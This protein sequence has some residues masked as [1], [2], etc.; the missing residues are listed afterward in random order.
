MAAL[1]SILDP[2]EASLNSDKNI[3]NKQDISQT[4]KSKFGKILDSVNNNYDFSSKSSEKISAGNSQENSQ[5]PVKKVSENRSLKQTEEQTQNALKDKSAANNEI[6]KK[7]SIEISKYAMP[8]NINVNNQNKLTNIIT[9]PEIMQNKKEIKQDKKDQKQIQK[10]NI[11]KN[12]NSDEQDKIQA[13]T[14]QIAMN[15]DLSAIHRQYKQTV[16]NNQNNIDN[17]KT[18]QAVQHKNTAGKILDNSEQTKILRQNLKYN[19]LQQTGQNILQEKQD[20]QFR[21]QLK[22]DSISQNKIQHIDEPLKNLTTK[23]NQQES[24]NISVEKN[25][26]AQS[27]PSTVPELSQNSSK[28]NVKIEQSQLEGMPN[29][30]QNETL[31]VSGK[32]KN[33]LEKTGIKFDKIE[34]ISV[35]TKLEIQKNSPESSLN[36]RNSQQHSENSSENALI[37]QISST[38]NNI[39][40]INANDNI[41]FD[42]IDKIIESKDL[43]QINP[44]LE[45]VNNKISNFNNNN[46]EITISLQPENL[47]KVDINLVTSNGTLTAQITTENLKVKDAL[48]KDLDV[49]KQNLTDQGIN[50]DKLEI[51]VQK[52]ET[53]NNNN[54]NLQQDSN[55]QKFEQQLNQ[56]ASSQNNQSDKQAFYGENINN[57]YIDINNNESE[58]DT[59][60]EPLQIND[61]SQANLGRVD[62]S[63]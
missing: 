23:Q 5:F 49:L 54:N 43:K 13:A 21:R 7:A 6:P 22:S 31:Q 2:K 4:D 30:K 25:T 16:Q 33:I 56:N 55:S 45:Q 17:T 19:N 29:I 8:K 61:S 42:K 1:Q 3:L 10:I 35:I 57:N 46:S 41:Q 34:D 51:N 40:G 32:N 9:S 38:H 28:I 39:A 27:I 53:S 62:Y 11:N 12:T 14:S 60:Q 47:G 58:N 63:V 37:Q 26:A 20:V 44:I 50:V 48:S 15:L 59:G 18:S 36:N 24:K 52:P